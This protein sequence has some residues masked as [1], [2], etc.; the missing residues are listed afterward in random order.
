MVG[1]HRDID[2]ATQSFRFRHTDTGSE[3]T[4][5]HTKQAALWVYNGQEVATEYHA[6][7][8]RAYLRRGIWAAAGSPVSHPDER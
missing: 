1:K 5:D 8:V 6:S 4:W 2:P 7:N 3:Y